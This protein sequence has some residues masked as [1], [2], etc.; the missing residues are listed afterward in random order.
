MRDLEFKYTIQEHGGSIFRLKLPLGEK[1]QF[2]KPCLDGQMGTI[3][4]IY[5]EWKISGDTIWLKNN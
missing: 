3:I 2:K 4:K 5:R 1:H